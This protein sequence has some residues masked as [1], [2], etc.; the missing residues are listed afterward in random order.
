[1]KL[2]PSNPGKQQVL[3]LLLSYPY[4]VVGVSQGHLFRSACLIFVHIFLIACTYKILEIVCCHTCAQCCPFWL[5]VDVSLL[6]LLAM[7]CKWNSV[8]N[9]CR[10]TWKTSTA[11]YDSCTLNLGATGHGMI[12]H[13]HH[14]LITVWSK[15]LQQF[16]VGTL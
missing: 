14:L 8:I 12:M 5:L 16:G 11:F 2:I 3:K 4:T 9:Y 10:I 7:M 15:K 6:L 13:V 1:M